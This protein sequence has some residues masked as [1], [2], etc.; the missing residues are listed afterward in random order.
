MDIKIKNY[1][2]IMG[3]IVLIAFTYSTIRVANIIEPSTIKSFTVIGEG[4]ITAIP[5]IAVF[6]F[7]ILTEGGTDIASLQAKNTSAANE[8]ISFVKKND[9]ADKDISTKGYAINPRYQYSDCS[10]ELLSSHM[11]TCPP[12]EI[13]GYTIS[14]TIQVKVRDF[15]NVGDIM[16]GIVSSG[17]NTVSG[18]SFDVDDRTK[19]ENEARARAITAATERA[20]T[21]AKAGHFRIGDVVSVSDGGISSP[22][23]YRTFGAVS[24]ESAMDTKFIPSIE[25][26]SQDINASVV[27][28][29]TIK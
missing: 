25:P 27:I 3:I 17:A 26:G 28:T 24:N 7:G 15:D 8:A 22:M 13:V 14:Q 16:R 2:G 6:S 9:V 21:I 10:R 23:S 5:D 4:K 18:L 1:L 20:K 29:Y 11:A 12:P 19:L